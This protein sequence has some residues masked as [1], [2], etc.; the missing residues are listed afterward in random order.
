MV[1]GTSRRLLVHIPGNQILYIVHSPAVCPCLCQTKL[2][3]THVPEMSRA[4]KA[5][6][7]SQG[8][9]G[10]HLAPR[11]TQVTCSQVIRQLRLFTCRFGH[12]HLCVYCAM[13]TAEI[14]ALRGKKWC[15]QK[16]VNIYKLKLGLQTDLFIH[17]SIHWRNF[18]PVQGQEAPI[19]TLELLRDQNPIYSKLIFVTAN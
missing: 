15:T 5:Q 13:S 17:P 14:Q 10:F 8:L 7:K 16:D 18:L 12:H 2:S 1:S 19:L 9:S 11:N 4:Y 3:F 6:V